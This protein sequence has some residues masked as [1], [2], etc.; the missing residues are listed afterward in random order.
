[1]EPEAI[2]GLAPVLELLQELVDAEQPLLA[3][4]V[5]AEDGVIPA[6]HP[7]GRVELAGDAQPALGDELQE[8][9]LVGGAGEPPVGEG[10]GLLAGAALGAAALR[11]PAPRRGLLFRGLGG[12]RGGGAARGPGGGGG[13]DRLG[14]AALVH[15]A[16]R[17]AGRR[18]GGGNGRGR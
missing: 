11:R 13:L 7:H 9:L 17:R 8:D 15:A 6:L 5:T 1:M 18:G 16:G 10:D 2:A 14:A 4:R 3:V 12:A